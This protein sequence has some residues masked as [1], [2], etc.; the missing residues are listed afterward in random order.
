[1]C[2]NLFRIEK[3]LPPDATDPPTPAMR[4]IFF[5]RFVTANFKSATRMGIEQWWQSYGI[6]DRSRHC[7]KRSRCGM[8]N[9]AISNPGE[10]WAQAQVHALHAHEAQK[11]VPVPRL[12]SERELATDAFGRRTAAA[13]PTRPLSKVAENG[14]QGIQRARV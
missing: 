4:P 7:N 6:E 5:A 2:T 11:A 13:P 8:W 9:C 12:H 1:M 10:D 14:Y 3:G